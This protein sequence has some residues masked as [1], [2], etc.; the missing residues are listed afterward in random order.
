M[1]P[2]ISQTDTH[3]IEPNC[4][5]EARHDLS[6]YQQKLVDC[7]FRSIPE[8]AETLPHF[9]FDA[10]EV[11]SLFKAKYERKFIDSIIQITKELTKAI[12]HFRPRGST[13]HYF[14]PWMAV[15]KYDE[16]TNQISLKFNQ[17]LAPHILELRKNG[18]YTPLEFG[19]LMSLKSSYSLRIYRIAKQ[20][21]SIGK[22]RYT[23][24]DLRALFA[25]GEKEYPHYGNLKDR[26]ILTAV[27]E[28]NKKTDIEITFTEH[29]TGHAVSAIEFHFKPKKNIAKKSMDPITEVLHQN[30]YNPKEPTSEAHVQLSARLQEAGVSQDG[31]RNIISM[32]SE[33]SPE[34]IEDVWDAIGAQIERY[35]RRGESYDMPA[36]VTKFFTSSWRQTNLKLDEETTNAKKKREDLEKHYEEI[37]RRKKKYAILKQRAIKNLAQTLDEEEKKKLWQKAESHASIG[38]KDKSFI[39]K[40]TV[41]AIYYDLLAER[42]GFPEFN[43]WKEEG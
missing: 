1:I 21:R 17:E 37:E 2:K 10:K 11:A 36:V 31:I 20:Y 3:F 22:R 19:Q 15:C 24:P 40:Y 4:I 18:N 42:A 34:T 25:L 7:M 41:E 13:T 23:I 14:Y 26:I 5:V 6:T 30:D 38:H 27:N 35:N 39:N 28:I 8:D 33:E 9:I 16:A 12:L 32:Y 29:K 43:D